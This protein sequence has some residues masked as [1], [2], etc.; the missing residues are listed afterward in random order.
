MSNKKTLFWYEMLHRPVGIGCQPKGFV[1]TDDT[2]GNYG[3]V[4]YDRKLTEEELSEYEMKE[5]KEVV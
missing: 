3:L 2:L 5:W 1:A 4:A